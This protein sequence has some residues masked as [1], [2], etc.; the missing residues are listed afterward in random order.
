MKQE[1]ATKKFFIRTLGWPLV[2]VPRY[3]FGHIK[4]VKW[5]GMMELSK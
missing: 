4:R 5:F 3:D 2:Q 1:V